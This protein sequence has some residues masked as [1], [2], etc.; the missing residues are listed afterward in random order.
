MP[1]VT[2]TTTVCATPLTSMSFQHTPAARRRTRGGSRH[3]GTERS[4]RH[5]GDAHGAHR[6]APHEGRARI[7][8]GGQ[9]GFGIKAAGQ[10]LARSFMRAGLWT[11][12]LTEYPSLIRGGHNVI[13]GPRQ[14]RAVPQP[15]GRRRHPRRAQ[16]RDG[17]PPPGLSSSRAPRS[18]TTPTSVD[19]RGLARRTSAP[20]PVRSTRSPKRNGGAIMRNTV[21]LGAALA[22]L[23]FP[24]EPFESLAARAVRAQVARDRRAE[25][26]APRARATR[27]PRGPRADFPLAARARARAR[28][29]A[30]SSTATRRSASARSPRASASTP[31][32]R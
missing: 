29:S 27:R 25:R 8:I 19:G 22:L 32:T 7:K 21:A 6:R 1:P 11:F 18:S 17:R 10:T 13:T 2:P 9:A 5:G 4:I 26:R 12:D 20:V 24:L 23:H 16:P 28:R 14:P 31:R 3:T 15:R 30:S